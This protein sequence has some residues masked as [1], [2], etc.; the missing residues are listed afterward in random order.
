[1]NH[2]ENRTQNQSQLTIDLQNWADSLY[3][4]NLRKRVQINC[5]TIRRA[6][7]LKWCVLFRVE[8][9]GRLGAW[10]Q[11]IESQAQRNDGRP[12]TARDGLCR[13]FTDMP[14]HD[15]SGVS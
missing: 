7:Q 12:T 5:C 14:R 13:N 9:L 11:H 8:P 6:D 10:E 15:S 2:K 3:A 1:M 4:R